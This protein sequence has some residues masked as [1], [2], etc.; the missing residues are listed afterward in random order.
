ME[1]KRN[2]DTIED[3]PVLIGDHLTDGNFIRDLND[4]RLRPDEKMGPGVIAIPVGVGMLSLGIA[5]FF[6]EAIETMNQMLHQTDQMSPMLPFYH[7]IK[8][9]A[10][11]LGTIA[12]SYA[13]SLLIG[14]GIQKISQD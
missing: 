5:H 11:S 2:M 1:T 3:A 10:E 12:M 4:P 13:G 9:I 6:P 8:L 14:Y 7:S